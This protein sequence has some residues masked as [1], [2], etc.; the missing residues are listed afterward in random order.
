MRKQCH[1]YECYCLA[2]LSAPST[3]TT[4]S[5]RRP[6]S[7]RSTL[8]VFPVGSFQNFQNRIFASICN[9]GILPARSPSARRPTFSPSTAV[10]R[11]LISG[12]HR[13]CANE[14]FF[15]AF[16]AC[17]VRK[18]V[19]LSRQRMVS[20][21]QDCFHCLNTSTSPIASFILLHQRSLLVQAPSAPT[22]MAPAR[23]S[24][25]AH[26][27]SRTHA[28]PPTGARSCMHRCGCFAATEIRHVQMCMH[29][30]RRAWSRTR[31]TKHVFSVVQLL[32]RRRL[33]R[34]CVQHWHQLRGGL[35]PVKTVAAASDQGFG[36]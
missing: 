36:Q 35:L 26:S 28:P 30:M 5:A 19:R 18:Q 25:A 24:P 29:C 8:V 7:T 17:N 6:T 12:R 1:I 4:P 21:K 23:A 32:D 11:H 9:L 34:F 3:T 31:L 27:R 33:Q 13:I 20:S 22:P 14:C 10:V 15:I 16:C 2:A